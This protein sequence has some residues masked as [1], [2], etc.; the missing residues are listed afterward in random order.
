MFEENRAKEELKRVDHLIYVTLKY[1]RTCDVIKSVI[2]RL[3]NAFEEAFDQCL[4]Y[5]KE[6]KKLKVIPDSNRMRAEMLQK[7]CNK[8]GIKKYFGLYYL[9][10]ELYVAEFGRKEEY[11]KHVAMV[12][13]LDKGKIVEVDIPVLMGYFDQTKEFVKIMEEW[14]K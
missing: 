12:C 13:R 1:T 8:R 4:E 5:A 10:R 9:F 7:V 2:E 14:T 11:R 3:I 6:K